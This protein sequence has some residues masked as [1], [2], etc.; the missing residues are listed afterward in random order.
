[1]GKVCFFTEPDD[2]GL[3]ISQVLVVHT[4]NVGQKLEY[5]YSFAN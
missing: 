1:M 2:I 5:Q 4:L 3:L